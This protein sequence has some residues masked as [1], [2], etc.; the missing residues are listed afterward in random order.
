M[1]GLRVA[2]LGVTCRL[3]CPDPTIRRPPNLHQGGWRGVAIEWLLG[4]HIALRN[5]CRLVAAMRGNDLE[6][7][8]LFLA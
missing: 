1:A 2:W 6:R 4:A 3:S 5:N 8:L 7:R